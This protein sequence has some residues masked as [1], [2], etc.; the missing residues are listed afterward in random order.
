MALKENKQWHQTNLP[1]VRMPPDQHPQMECKQE[2]AIYFNLFLFYIPSGYDLVQG[3]VCVCVCVC[4]GGVLNWLDFSLRN[5]LG[6][7]F[8]CVGQIWPFWRDE[9]MK[10]SMHFTHTCKWHT[11]VC[12]CVCVYI[13]IYIY[14]YVYVLSLGL[15]PVTLQS[16]NQVH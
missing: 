10:R 8:L 9:W 13:Y 15:E 7:C 16:P 14:I 1:T 12:V 2:T 3:G 6:I 4:V 5:T 11:L